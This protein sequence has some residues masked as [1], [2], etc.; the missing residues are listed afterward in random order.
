MEVKKKYEYFSDW[1]VLKLL[2]LSIKVAEHN[3]GGLLCSVCM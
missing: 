1:K 3:C 2:G